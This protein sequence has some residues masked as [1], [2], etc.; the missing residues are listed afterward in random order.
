MKKPRQPQVDL[1]FARAAHLLLPRGEVT[2]IALIGCGGTGSWL[3][4]SIARLARVVGESGREVKVVFIDGDTVE[5]KNIPRQNFC[6]AEIGMNKAVTLANRFGAAWGLEITAIPQMYS[7]DKTSTSKIFAASHFGL[8]VIVGCVDNAAARKAIA[9]LLKVNLP[10]RAH[11]IWWLDCGNANES[12]QV[13][14]GSAPDAKSLKGAFVSSKTCAALPSPVLQAPDLLVARPEELSASRMSCA[15][16]MMANMQALDVNQ[17]VA[18]IAFSYLSRMLTGIP[19]KR[20]AS[21]FDL[22]S[23]N[24]LSKPITLEALAVVCGKPVGFLMKGKG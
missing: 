8:Q 12:G 11:N 7:G 15:E 3:A 6:D 5:D 24:T 9:E 21:F 1:S 16:M 2:S 4:P 22:P 19:L 13:L 18:Q 20:F 23:G 14:L 10:N 17:A